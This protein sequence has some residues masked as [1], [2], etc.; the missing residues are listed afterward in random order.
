MPSTHFTK[1]LRETTQSLSSSSVLQ[2]IRRGCLT[3]YGWLTYGAIFLI[4]KALLVFITLVAI[5]VFVLLIVLSLILLVRDLLASIWT[6]L[7]SIG[8]SL[9]GIGERILS[10]G[11]PKYLISLITVRCGYIAAALGNRLLTSSILTSLQRWL[12]RRV[13][14]VPTKHGSR[15]SYRAKLLG[16]KLTEL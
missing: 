12:G 6:A 8:L 11:S 10:F 16:E 3:L 13:L 5:A 2:T 4:W 14:S 9:S 1:W 15:I 7:S